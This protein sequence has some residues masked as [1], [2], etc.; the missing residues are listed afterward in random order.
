[1]NEVIKSYKGFNRDLTCRG[2]ITS[3]YG[4][5]ISMIQGCR[6]G[7]CKLNADKNRKKR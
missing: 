3:F 7:Y 4:G 6:Y 5:K 2:K 1:M